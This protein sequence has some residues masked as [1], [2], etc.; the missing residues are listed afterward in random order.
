MG[1]I[2]QP[3]PVNVFD[4]EQVDRN[5]VIDN[6][7]KQRNSLTYTFHHNEETMTCICEASLGPL[8]IAVGQASS[9]KRDYYS[10]AVGEA[11]SRKKVDLLIMDK[12]VELE[13]YHQLRLLESTQTEG[14]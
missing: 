9:M 1:I 7:I 10:L 12:L 8:T 13:L 14:K 11:E 4:K 2:E 5:L 3:T 6:A